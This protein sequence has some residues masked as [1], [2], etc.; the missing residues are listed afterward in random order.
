M[1]GS[2]ALL[3]FKSTLLNAPF[4]SSAEEFRLG[5]V[6][7]MDAVFNEALFFAKESFVI[8]KMILA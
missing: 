8:S 4:L 2:M 6:C 5:G 1:S 3:V 7:F